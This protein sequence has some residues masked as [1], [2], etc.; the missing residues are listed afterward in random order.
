MKYRRVVVHTECRCYKQ[1]FH[2]RALCH[3]GTITNYNNVA[4]F[5]NALFSFNASISH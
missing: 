4:I 1:K 2:C 5:N 3:F